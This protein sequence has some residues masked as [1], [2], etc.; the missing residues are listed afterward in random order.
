MQLPNPASQPK[1]LKG[2]GK[3]AGH[4]GQHLAPVLRSNTSKP[5]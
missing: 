2:F 3:A 4:L 1:S 5:N